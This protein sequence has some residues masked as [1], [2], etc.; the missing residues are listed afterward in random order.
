[1]VAWI[2]S[3]PIQP[4]STEAFFEGVRK[5][6]L[7]DAADDPFLKDVARD[8]AKEREMTKFSIEIARLAD[9]LDDYIRENINENWTRW[10]AD[11]DLDTQSGF[12][13]EVK[14][15]D[16]ITIHRS[17]A[18][19]WRDESGRVRSLQSRKR[20]ERPEEIRG[21]DE[22]AT[23]PPTTEEALTEI[24]R[25]TAEA[26]EIAKALSDQDKVSLDEWPTVEEALDELARRISVVAKRIN[27]KSI[28]FNVQM[29]KMDKMIED[30]I[31]EVKKNAH[32][33][34]KTVQEVAHENRRRIK[35]LQADLDMLKRD[36]KYRTEAKD[37]F[38]DDMMKVK[39]NMRVAAEDNGQTYSKVLAAEKNIGH[40]CER[41]ADV[42]RRANR[43]LEHHKGELEELKDGMRL[44]DR[45][46]ERAFER[47]AALEKTD[48]ADDG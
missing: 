37:S 16:T 4:I 23:E 19:A 26:G 8:T 21:I 41:M 34:T 7:Q 46:V 12:I 10:V 48:T 43:I 30:E 24:A 47:L 31:A 22:A 28:G 25:T 20:Y 1:M 13:V 2:S 9:D 33:Y 45:G 42:E 38:I 36:L 6:V 35:E 5:Q 3:A 17:F 32:L 11:D 44:T 39:S 18:Y 15:A 14:D 29:D 40:L 27:K